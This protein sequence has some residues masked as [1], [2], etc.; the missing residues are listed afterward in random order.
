MILENQDSLIWQSTMMKV[1][2]FCLFVTVTIENWNK[3]HQNFVATY[4][5]LQNNNLE[6]SM[7][8]QQV[9]KIIIM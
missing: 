9:H 5:I 1:F 6:N 8:W 3:F 4:T 2:V 7:V